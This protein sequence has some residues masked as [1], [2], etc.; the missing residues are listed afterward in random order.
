MTLKLCLTVIYTRKAKFHSK[1]SPLSFLLTC[2]Q[3]WENA[4]LFETDF[5]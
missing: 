5:G 4:F 3:V 1:I 2:A